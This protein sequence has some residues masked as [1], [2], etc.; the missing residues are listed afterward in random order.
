[1]GIKVR[2]EH[3]ASDSD[4]KQ[5]FDRAA[6]TGPMRTLFLVLG[7]LLAAAHASGQ[8]APPSFE[9]NFS[10]PGARSMGLAGAFAALADDAT[11]VFAN[12]GGL[13]QLARPEVSLELRGWAYDTPFTVGGRLSGSPTGLGLD[14][15]PGLRSG[16]SSETLFGLSFV[17]LALPRER[18]TVAVYRHQLANFSVGTATQGVFIDASTTSIGLLL[19]DTRRIADLRTNTR[20]EIANYGVTGAYRVNDRF[21]VGVGLSYF[22]ADFLNIAN[23]YFFS[24][25]TLPDGP[26]G[27]HTFNPRALAGTVD[28]AIDDSDWRANGGFLWQVAP[29]WRVGGFYRQ[30]PT[31][32]IEGEERTGPAL[33]QLFPVG[34]VTDAATGSVGFP[35]VFG[36][37]IA[38]QSGAITVSAEWDRVEYSTI[39]RSLGLEPIA[40][41]E[42]AGIDD[43]N[44]FRFGGEHVFVRTTPILAI[45]GGIWFD[46]DHRVRSTDPISGAFYRGG[47]DHW[48]YT[49]GFGLAFSNFQIDIGIDVSALIDTASVSGVYS[50]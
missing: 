2:P 4:L 5:R 48:H 44:E 6:R 36:L 26:F 9:F 13:V 8:G 23:Q 33:G 15:V 50:F 1:M 22:H 27:R 10:N 11:A 34:T 45:R 3:V 14:T 40:E 49:G 25:A 18:W 46:P 35:D 21:S 47:S 30:A 29:R 39:I 20:V 43:A 38:Y 37:G 32:Q 12:P 41:T 31:F 42:G 28:I 24:P 7:I 19:Q 17:S 16:I